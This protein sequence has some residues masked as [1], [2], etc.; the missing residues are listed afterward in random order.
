MTN[1]DGHKQV[2]RTP[3]HGSPVQP[4]TTTSNIKLIFTYTLTL[5]MTHPLSQSQAILLQQYD[6]KPTLK[7]QYASRKHGNTKD[8]THPPTY[9]TSSG[10]RPKH[11]LT[12]KK[13]AICKNSLCTN[14]ERRKEEMRRHLFF[15]VCARKSLIIPII[16]NKKVHIILH[17]SF[18]LS[19]FMDHF[20]IIA[21]TSQKCT[22]Q[23]QL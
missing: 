13:Q 20:I 16:E 5:T 19:L 9:R 15:H 6:P 1:V 11:Y 7:S 4:A 8:N 14:P 22:L 10:T 21:A 2:K 12:I 18:E 3:K 23:C 17:F